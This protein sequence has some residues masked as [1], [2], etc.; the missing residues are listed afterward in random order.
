MEYGL[1]LELFGAVSYSTRANTYK[2]RF[3]ALLAEEYILIDISLISCSSGW[4]N[5]AERQK[6][7]ST[8]LPL[9]SFDSG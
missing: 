8:T 9:L 4:M 7:I 3:S 1:D 6:I 5:K 2:K